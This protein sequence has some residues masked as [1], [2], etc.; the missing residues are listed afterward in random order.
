[1]TVVAGEVEMPSPDTVEP[2]SIELATSS[3][4][5]LKVIEPWEKLTSDTAVVEP[6]VT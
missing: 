5:T 4:A 2:T 1:M 3:E 6:A